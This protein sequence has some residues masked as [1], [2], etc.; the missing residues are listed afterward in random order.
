MKVLNEHSNRCCSSFSA[1]L[2]EKIVHALIVLN[3][4]ND[5]EINLMNNGFKIGEKIRYL[6]TRMQL[7]RVRIGQ[8]SYLVDGKIGIIH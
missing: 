3:R 6:Q 8:F 4:S 2:I 1:S 5:N 7:L